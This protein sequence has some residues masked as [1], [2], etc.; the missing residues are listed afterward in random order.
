MVLK[1]KMLT[2]HESYFP[3]ADSKGNGPGN[4]PNKLN[5]EGDHKG[6]SIDWTPDGF[7]VEFKNTAFFLPHAAAKGATF[8]NPSDMRVY[9]K[10]ASEASS[11]RPKA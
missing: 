11:P 1:V 6:M 9:L 2:L 3:G 10:W 8:V 7:F 5:T 4:L